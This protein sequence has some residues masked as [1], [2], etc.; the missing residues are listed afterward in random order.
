[1]GAGAGK[2]TRAVF[3]MALLLTLPTAVSYA[4]VAR[5][6]PSAGSAYA[7]LSEAINPLIGSW[8]GFLL[9]ATYFIAVVL[10][11]ILFSL[12]FNDLVGVRLL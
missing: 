8:V 4:L 12:F 6:I 5:E 11:P 2:A 1:M 9:T 3:L 7:W 10:Q